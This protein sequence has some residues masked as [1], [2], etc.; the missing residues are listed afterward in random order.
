MQVSFQNK[1]MHHSFVKVPTENFGFFNFFK[2]NQ[3]AKLV[4]NFGYLSNVPYIEFS[5]RRMHISHNKILIYSSL[6]ISY[7]NSNP[8]LLS[9]GG[10]K[11][12]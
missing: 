6:E 9:K 7:N 11:I 10:F 5:L 1:I 3:T 8:I 12:S 4:S 2:N